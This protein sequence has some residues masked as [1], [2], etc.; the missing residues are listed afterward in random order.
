M[1]GRGT[2]FTAGFF[3]GL[4]GLPAIVAVF[5]VATFTFLVLGDKATPDRGRE[6]PAAFWTDGGDV[7]RSGG[8]SIVMH[9]ADGS[10]TRQACREACDDLVFWS[11]AAERVEVRGAGGDCIVCEERGLQLPLTAPRRQ[12][13]S[14]NPVRLNEKP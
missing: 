12:G 5:Y 8:A 10:V 6:I 2:R 13:L 1:L 4:F 9:G 7:T 3:V 14:G 11:G